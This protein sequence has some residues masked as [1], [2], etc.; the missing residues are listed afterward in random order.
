VAALPG[1]TGGG[2]AC[3]GEGAR[4]GSGVGRSRDV[5]GWEWDRGQREGSR[6]RPRGRSRPG[7]V[8]METWKMTDCGAAVVCGG[9]QKFDHVFVTTSFFLGVEISHKS[10]KSL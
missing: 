10:G 3:A 5:G 4:G 2:G 9:G 1:P 7:G 8:K 6:N